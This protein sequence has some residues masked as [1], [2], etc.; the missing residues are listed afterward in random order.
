MKSLCTDSHLFLQLISQNS[1]VVAAV[2]YHTLQE[3]NSRH[4]EL[5]EAFYRSD[6]AGSYASGGLLVPIR[7]I[8]RLSGI[9]I[10]RYDFSEPQAGKGP[11]DR[12]AAH[13]KAHVNRFLNEGNDLTPAVHMKRALESRGGVRNVVPYVVEFPESEHTLPMPR[14]SRCKS[15]S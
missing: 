2:M 9:S 6:C 8:G 12:S 15:S 7:H 14:I 4:P 3:E 10:K 1:E 11:C 5:S 13:Q